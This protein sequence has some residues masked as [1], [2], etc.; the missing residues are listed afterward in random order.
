MIKYISASWYLHV[1]LESRNVEQC[2][3]CK[4]LNIKKCFP[5][6]S[7]GDQQMIEHKDILLCIIFTLFG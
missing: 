7:V 3:V 5:S 4:E 1:L 6:F 2:W